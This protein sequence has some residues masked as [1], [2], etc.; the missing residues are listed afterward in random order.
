MVILIFLSPE[1]PNKGFVNG[2]ISF[3]AP[4]TKDF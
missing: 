2:E 3:V 4:P 1:L